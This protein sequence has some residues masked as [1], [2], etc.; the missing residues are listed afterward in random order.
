MVEQLQWDQLV[1]WVHWIDRNNKKRREK[2]QQSVKTNGS[3]EKENLENMAS[4]P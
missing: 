1:M 3:S 4:Q 2:K